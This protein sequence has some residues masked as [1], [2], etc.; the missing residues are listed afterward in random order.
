MIKTKSNS[1]SMTRY[2]ADLLLKFIKND[3]SQLEILAE[4]IRLTKLIYN[5]TNSL[6]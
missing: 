3:S 1:C 2:F 5:F 4:F 6:S